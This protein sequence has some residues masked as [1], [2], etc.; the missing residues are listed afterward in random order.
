MKVCLL[1]LTLMCALNVQSSEVC[2]EQGEYEKALENLE[3]LIQPKI[4]FEDNVHKL[5][6]ITIIRSRLKSD[7][8]DL[9]EFIDTISND[10]LSILLNSLHFVEKEEFDEKFQQRV[11]NLISKIEE[12]R[13]LL[14]STFN[15]TELVNLS[16]NIGITN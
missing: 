8:A 4:S 12:S 3:I 15:N 2:L 16:N 1:I 10:L 6:L 7:Q 9:L 13:K 11:F 5:E 14:P